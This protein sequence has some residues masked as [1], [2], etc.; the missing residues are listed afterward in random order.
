MKNKNI[1]R[2]AAVF[3]MLVFF[4]GALVMVVKNYGKKSG[5]VPT[6]K[7]VF[8][9]DTACTAKVWGAQA[10]D[11]CG[12]IKRLEGIF[13]CH[14]ESSE[15]SKL[16]ASGEAKLSAEARELIEQSVEL[17][18]RYPD[19]DITL[20]AVTKLWNVTGKEPRV[21]SEEQIQIAL[22]TC[23]Y[24]NIKLE[25]D[26]CTLANGAQLDAGA[27]A[28]G[29]ALD[30]AMEMLKSSEAECAV[31]TMGSS[32][33]MYGRKPDGEEFT[34]A[35]RDP[36]NNDG[37]LLKFRTGECFVSTSGGYERFFEANGER[38]IHIFDKAAGKPVQTDLTS[39]TVVCDNGLQSDQLATAIFIGGTKKL[40]EYFA[41]KSI[42]IIAVDAQGNIHVSKALEEKITLND[43]RHKII[44]EG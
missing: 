36:E 8:A 2:F 19:A 26:R 34:V 23:G 30:K 20:G 40:G 22:Q 7:T 1:T 3:A 6:E 42:K 13:D 43:T 37:N 24:E 39:V 11:I 33:L 38:Y 10:E 5:S 4:A 27:V 14:S 29:Y 44:V 25:G 31:V 35:V 21:P 18:G 28:K 16:N 32:S 17:T 41:D 9:M 15:F 12:E